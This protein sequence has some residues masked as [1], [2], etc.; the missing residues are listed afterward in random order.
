MVDPSHHHISYGVLAVTVLV[1][2]LVVAWLVR[3]ATT[4][5]FSFN[6]PPLVAAEPV[7]GPREGLA[8]CVQTVNV[9]KSVQAEDKKVIDG[10]LPEFRQFEE[11]FPGFGQMP[12]AVDSGCPIGPAVYD[13]EA[14]PTLADSEVELLPVFCTRR[15]K[16]FGRYSLLIYIL[17]KAEIERL[18]HPQ[19]SR[20]TTEEEV[21]GGDVC[22]RKTSGLLLSPVEAREPAVLRYWLYDLVGLDCYRPLDPGLPDEVGFAPYVPEDCLAECNEIN[23]PLRARHVCFQDIAR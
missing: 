10:L 5:D 6:N 17:P 22:D 12:E 2:A 18:T 1:G 3:D 20:F 13:D 15:V 19:R 16:E 7:G 9:D 4:E 11:L 14:C 21:C 8:Y 23:L